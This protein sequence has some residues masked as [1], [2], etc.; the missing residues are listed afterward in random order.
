MA[1]ITQAQ[2]ALLN[3]SFLDQLA[4]DQSFTADLSNLPLT[5]RLLIEAAAVFVQNARK[6]LN[7]PDRKGRI[8]ISTGKLESAIKSFPIRYSGSSIEMDL[9]YDPKNPASRYGDFVNEG[10]RGIKS[11]SEAPQ[12]P[13]SFKA[14]KGV[15]PAPVMV[16]AIQKWIKDNKR[17]ND[18]N[19]DLR[20]SRG[21]VS[22]GTLRSGIALQRKRKKLTEL[23]KD[24]GIAYAI[25]TNIRKKGLARSGF[26]DKAVEQTFND[27]F[28]R[29]VA[30]VVGADVSI[31]IR[32]LNSL[33]NQ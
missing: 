6:N 33:S 23:Q 2:A 10:V 9:G 22:G 24:K 14:S 5:E 15:T 32:R 3:T 11:Q 30:D 12:S 17:L 25:A 29:A 18:D 16:N 31:G 4:K 27:S 1:S 21:G 26:F 7:T 20:G 13:Y 19:P 28:F 8:R